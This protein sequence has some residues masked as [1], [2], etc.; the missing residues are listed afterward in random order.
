MSITYEEALSTLN[1]MFGAPWNSSYLDAVLR[2]FAGHMENTVEAILS[3]GDGA[4]DELIT[5]LKSSPKPSTQSA[6]PGGAG[7]DSVQISMDEELARA[8]AQED[9]TAATMQTNSNTSAPITRSQFM[10]GGGFPSDP[11]RTQ[12]NPAAPKNAPPVPKKKGRGTPVELP[13]D[14]LRIPGRKYTDIDADEAL[15]RMLQDDLFTEELAN[16]PEFAHL[17][18]GRLPS[19]ASRYNQQPRASNV[20]YGGNNAGMGGGAD[21][22]KTISDMGETAK[23]RLALFASNWNAKQ[24]GGTGGNVGGGERRGLL[25]APTENEEEVIFRGE[26][27]EL[28]PMSQQQKQSPGWATS[29]KDK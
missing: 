21:F 24:G 22:M 16:N 18:R 25:D 23:K 14:F 2:H 19:Q 4:P 15:A 1:S 20:H 12:T 29:K 7:L 27:M 3:H 28:R 17:A 10:S 5:S 26:G 6:S 8:L 11:Q 9:Q 13:A